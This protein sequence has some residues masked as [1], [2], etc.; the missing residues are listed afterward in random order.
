MKI[1]K[2]KRTIAC[3]CALGAMWRGGVAFA[4]PAEGYGLPSA[5]EQDEQS[6][7]AEHISPKEDGGIS[8]DDKETME[9]IET[10]TADAGRAQAGPALTPPQRAAICAAAV[11][12]AAYL[13]CAAITAD[14][15]IGSVLTVGSLA[16]PC[17]LLV[18]LACGTG[19]GA[20]GVV[21]TY[22]PDLVRR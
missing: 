14:C 13:G 19:F 11:Q 20:A 8:W 7:Q 15:A 22:C 21:A 17:V 4:A 1:Y 12:V 16:I 2:Q 18:A 3:L 9:I 5:T 6:R 10:C